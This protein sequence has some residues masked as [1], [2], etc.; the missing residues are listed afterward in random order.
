MFNLSLSDI[1]ADTNLINQFRTQCCLKVPI[2]AQERLS[3][4]N[5]TRSVLSFTPDLEALGQHIRCKAENHKLRRATPLQQSW[6]L[7]IHCEYSDIFSFITSVIE[8]TM[9]YFITG[10]PVFFFHYRR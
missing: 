9:N 10:I 1:L 8:L 5:I 3:N 4:F 7:T 2:S 6:P